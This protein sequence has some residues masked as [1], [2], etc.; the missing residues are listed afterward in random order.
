[1]DTH[2]LLERLLRIAAGIGGFI[3]IFYFFKSIIRLGVLNERYQDSLAFWVGR[4]ALYFFRLRIFLIPG[5]MQRRNQI[6]TWYWPCALFGVI[7]VWFVLVMVAFAL[8]NIAFGAEQSF[9]RALVSSGSALSTLGFSTPS[10][11]AGQYL[12]IVE[13]GIGLFVVVYLFTFLPGFM[14]LIHERDQRIA[15]IYARVNETPS[16]IDLLEWFYNNHHESDLSMV[17]EDWELFFRRLAQARSFLPLLCVIRPV[18]LKQSWIAGIGALMDA[19][20]LKSTVVANPRG[21]VRI[22]F[23]CGVRAIQNFHSSMRGTPIGPRRNLD[24]SSIPREHFDAAC[25]RLVASGV[26]ILSDRDKA[27]KLFLEAH[28]QYAGEIAWLAAAISDPLP[29]WPSPLKSHPPEPPTPPS[30]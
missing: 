18:A 1:M 30:A 27:W 9:T 19:L 23:D 13:G 25:D 4:I 24:L 21:G 6:M 15:W 28:R 8:L 14:D 5:G 22:C 26:T 12:A 16:G 3:C 11:F 10:T 20:A 29:I 2:L 17:L 7:T